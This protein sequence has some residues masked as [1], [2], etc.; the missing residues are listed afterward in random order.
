MSFVEVAL[1]EWNCDAVTVG[2]PPK[3]TTPTVLYN[4]KIPI[5]CIKSDDAR[6]RYV[7]SSRHGLTRS[8][9]YDMTSKKFTDAWDGDWGISF[10]I[11][12]CINE[13]PHLAIKLMNLF[14]DIERKVE[15]AYEK[16]PH[17][18]LGYTWLIEKN[19]FGVEKKVSID[20]SKGCYMNSKV[21]YDAPDDAPKIKIE[22]KEVPVLESRFPK[23][24]F[25]DVTRSRSS[26]RVVNPDTECRISMNAIPKIMISVF[27]SQQGVFITKRLMQC[28]YEPDIGGGDNVD[29]DLVE[30][31]RNN[32]DI[33]D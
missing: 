5:L 11:T 2:L 31:L 32:I 10:M 33:T 1:Y 9:K 12:K 26:I 24:K 21:P 14:E 17:P 6:N 8:M 19:Q 23:T 25:Y 22:G 4:G 18:P 27:A 29:D 16:K 20:K 3:G 7:V 28:Y 13:A 15:L 30:S